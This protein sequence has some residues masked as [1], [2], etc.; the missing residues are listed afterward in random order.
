MNGKTINII[1]SICMIMS[2][3]LCMAGEPDHGLQIYLPRE[4]TIQDDNVSLGKVSVMRGSGW[5]VARAGELG[6]GRISSR[7]QEII[8]DRPTILSRLASSGIP[9]S[10]VILTGAEKVKVRRQQ[11]IIKGSE[12]VELAKSFLQKSAS[13]N[14]I[15][16]WDVIR[17]PEDLVL[18][19]AVKDIKLQPSSVGSG[20]RNQAKVK[21]AVLADGLEVGVRQVPLRLKYNCRRVVTLAELA[22][23]ET[24][25]P[26]NI[27]IETVVSDRPEPP[28]W[29]APYGLVARR[30]LAVETVIRPEMLRA[31]RLPVII[32]RNQSV[33]IRIDLP[34]LLVTGSGQAIQDGRAGEYI[35]VRNTDSRRIIMARVQED[36]TVEPVL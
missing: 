17:T 15:C 33:V 8:V 36:G 1:V 31:A 35:K 20:I 4:V 23:G 7:G 2:G 19:A 25:S 21:I 12:F 22:P 26:Q 24:L 9:A 14:R 16:R 6:L 3:R 5:L 11:L 28:N 30:R 18:S 10:K 13:S 32:K 34:G 27:K 29:T